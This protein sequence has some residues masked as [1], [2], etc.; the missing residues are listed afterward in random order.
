MKKIIIATDY[1]A[2]AENALVYAARAAAEKQYELVLFSLQNASIHVLNARLPASSMTAHL[3]AKEEHLKES[4][5]RV[6]REFGIE[7]TSYFATGVFFDEL[8]RCI[9]NTGA[10]MVVMGMAD[11]SLEQDMMGN[12]TTAAIHRLKTPILAVPIG[13]SFNGIQHI[14]FACDISRGV[15]KRVLGKVRDIAAGFNAKVEIFNVTHAISDLAQNNRKDIDE[16]MAG[17]AY[18]YNDVASDDVIGAI[19]EEIIAR[20]ADLLIMVPYKYGFWSSLVHKSKTRIMAS[21]NSI[22]LLS[23]HL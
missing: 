11:K 9:V 22:P 12:T 4:A 16:S 20:K 3:A 13:A 5:E 10:D 1:S 14:V 15:H 8:E 21:G 18:Y 19:K 23:L 6:K 7:A 17:M 2:E